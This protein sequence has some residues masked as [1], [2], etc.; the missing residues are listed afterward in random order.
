L[1]ELCQ[2]KTLKNVI[3]CPTSRGILI[4]Q[5]DF[6]SIWINGVAHPLFEL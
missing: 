2:Y 5:L 1:F 6:P 3:I 4:V